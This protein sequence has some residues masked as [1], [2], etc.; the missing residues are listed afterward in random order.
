MQ[1][2]LLQILSGNSWSLVINPVLP[3]QWQ[4]C[5]VLGEFGSKKAC[6]LTFREGEASAEW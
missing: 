2:M 1:T 6:I 5:L 4:L 3:L